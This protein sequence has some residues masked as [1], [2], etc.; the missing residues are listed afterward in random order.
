MILAD[1]SDLMRLSVAAHELLVGQKLRT[2]M[3]H[4]LLI[5]C[6]LEADFD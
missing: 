3:P 1:I 5:G 4:A 2:S 6:N